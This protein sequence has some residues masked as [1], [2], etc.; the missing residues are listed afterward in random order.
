MLS[1]SVPPRD[2]EVTLIAYIGD[3]PGVPVSMPIKWKGPIVAEVKKPRLFALLVG[4]SDY[5]NPDLKLRYAAADAT[6]MAQVLERQQ[7]G[8]T[9]WSTS[10]C[11]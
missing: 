4:I 8:F 5:E 6:S 3:Q 7:A 1:L 2:S 11:S 10:S 9:S